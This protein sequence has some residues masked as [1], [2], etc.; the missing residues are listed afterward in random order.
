[1]RA[2]RTAARVGRGVCLAAAALGVSAAGGVA[3]VRYSVGLRCEEDVAAAH[4]MAGEY[5]RGWEGAEGRAAGWRRAAITHQAEADALRRKL[6]F[7]GAPWFI[8]AIPDADDLPAGDLIPPQRV[9][10]R[11]AD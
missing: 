5:R 9:P 11:E 10:T 4:Q 2:G 8:P 1:M 6:M 3:M 7:G